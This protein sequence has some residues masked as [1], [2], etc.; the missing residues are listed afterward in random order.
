MSTRDNSTPCIS[1]IIAVYNVEKYIA[2]CC[3]SLF[4][5]T[6]ENLEYIFID[7]CSPDNS[8]IVVR[9]VLEKYP[10]RIH[11]VKI[12]E[13]QTNLG[14]SKARE[15][16]VKAA[17]GEYIIHC[18][19]DDWIELD[20]YEQLYNKAISEHLDFVTC[21]LWRHYY[22]DPKPYFEN[23]KPKELT[24]RS[25]L[26]SCLHYRLPFLGCFLWNK[27]IKSS[28]YYRVDWPEKISFGEDMA[29]CVQIL[30]NPSLK[31]GYVAKPLYHYRLNEKSLSQ[32]VN[33]KQ[34]IENDYKL[35]SILYSH[36]GESCDEEI[37]HMWQSCTCGLMAN[38]LESPKRFFSNNEYAKKYRKYRNCVWKNKAYPTRKKILLY[39][40]TY[41]YLIAFTLYKAGKRLITFTRKIKA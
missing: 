10:Q 24:S 32:R 20:M 3:H 22:N 31:I 28:L 29:A 16:G 40:A 39:Y 7:D 34:D 4:A 13:H 41:N 35:I 23:Q 5:Q 36:L 30:K 19:P 14:V 12:I 1:I 17:T 15:H 11:Q 9:T 8:I 25:T 2:Q 21:D 18:D 38:T 33:T 26:A 6:L 27:L 37:Y